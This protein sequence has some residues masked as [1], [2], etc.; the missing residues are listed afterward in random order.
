MSLFFNEKEKVYEQYADIIKWINLATL[1][2]P[3]PDKW[4]QENLSCD[5]IN[6][7]AEILIDWGIVDKKTAN[8][9]LIGLYNGSDN[10]GS[11][12]TEIGALINKMR[13]I[14]NTKD[15]STE[16]I[17]KKSASIY[18]Q[19]KYPKIGIIPSD[20][21]MG[22]YLASR[23]YLAGIYS[24]EEAMSTSIKMAQKLQS[25]FNS[26]DDC[27]ENIFWGAQCKLGFSLYNNDSR[28]TKTRRLY[29]K[30]K[31]ENNGIYAIDWKLPLIDEWNASNFV[32]PDTVKWF[33]AAKAPFNVFNKVTPHVYWP[34]L[35]KQ[36]ILDYLNNNW[37]IHN[38]QEAKEV[39]KTFL[40]GTHSNEIFLE[41]WSI[42]K[43]MSLM[44]YILDSSNKDN[45]AD[46]LKCRFNL[47][48]LIMENYPKQGVIAYDLYFAMFLISCC[49]LT[50]YFTYE[51]A[52]DTSLIIAKTIQENFFSWDDYMNNHF[53]GYQIWTNQSLENPLINSK[54]EKGEIVDFTDQST[55]MRRKIYN[56]LKEEKD[57]VYN[58]PWDTELKKEW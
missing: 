27:I 9:C 42:M 22:M 20:L 14:Q 58:I 50:G 55:E 2:Y 32:Y 30:I 19:H 12:K 46:F 39:I 17:L 8:H 24:F 52:L 15:N 1:I 54:L 38:Q 29:N 11:Y 7:A 48:H 26:W 21:T 57:S 34:V 37:K 47:I 23:L 43:G 51:E 28:V 18:I 56:C 45:S 49:Y 53:L 35:S 36:V 41:E 44:E 16:S 40:E 13:G 25:Y 3:D 33:N 6:E 4:S 10:F 31:K 5:T